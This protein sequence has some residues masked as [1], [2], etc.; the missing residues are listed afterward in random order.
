MRFKNHDGYGS[1]RRKDLPEIQFIV[2]KNT[3]TDEK[4]VNHSVV[5]SEN[6]HPYKKLRSGKEEKLTFNFLTIELSLLFTG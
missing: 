1:P 4:P 6:G 3:L 2:Q 5:K